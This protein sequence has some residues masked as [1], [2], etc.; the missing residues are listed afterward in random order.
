MEELK[1]D[2]QLRSEVGSSKIRKIRGANKVPAVVYGGKKED[3]TTIIQVDRRNFEKIMRTQKGRNVIFHLNV[4]EGEKKLRDYSAIIKEEQHDPVSDRLLHIDFQRIS[5]TEEIEVKVRVEAKGVPIGV[6]QDG[7]SLE[8]ILWDL[9]VRCLPTKIPEKLT[10]EVG[11]LKIGDSVYVKHIV[12][13]EG[14][15]TKHDMEAIVMTVVPP[16]KEEV[17]APTAA[18]GVAPSIEPEIIKKEK[19]AKD[20][21]GAAEEPKGKEK[22]APG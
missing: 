6:R 4:M 13:P 14:V 7:G 11:E 21:E 10:V 1:L 8:H 5:L 16:M 22:A 18:E 9:D 3:K 17:A 12:F 20:E 15:K 2:V 19:K